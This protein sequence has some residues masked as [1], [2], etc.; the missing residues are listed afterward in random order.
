LVENVNFRLPTKK[1]LVVSFWTLFLISLQ[2]LRIRK[3]QNHQ[4]CL[5][6][7]RYT[8]V[9]FENPLL[10]NLQAGYK[11][12]GRKFGGGRTEKKTEN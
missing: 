9:K 4:K 8:R 11:G 5:L 6:M 12:I 3:K 10:R 1:R 2:P 7:Q